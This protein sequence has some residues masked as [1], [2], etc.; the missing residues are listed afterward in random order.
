LT[1]TAATGVLSLTAL[2]VIPTT[3]EESNWNTAYG[4]GNHAGLYTPIAHKTTEDAI[5]GLV[6]CNGA[7]TYSA[8]TIGSD[9]QAYNAGLAD[10]AAL[11]KTDSNVIVGNG[12]NWV[13][14]SGATVRTSLGLGT[15]DDVSFKSLTLAGTGTQLNAS[16]EGAGFL[17]VTNVAS[18]VQPWH[19]TAYTCTK[20]RGTLA[21]PTAVQDGDYV[22]SYEATAY[23]G[24]QQRYVGGF[25]L[26]IEGAVSDN[27]TPSMFYIDTSPGFNGT[28]Y[29][30]IHSNGYVGIGYGTSAVSEMLQVNGKIRAATAFNLNG[31]DGVTQAAS[32]GKVCDVTALAG[33][34]ATAQTQIT[35]IADGAHSLAGITSI[36]TANGRITAMS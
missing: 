17:I 35:Y 11:A 10:I 12:T 2:Y 15:T 30:C 5:N 14:E 7:G 31:T 20:S 6:F 26:N 34:I 36:T 13:A 25:F 27:N 24:D 3:T 22:F 21:S 19:R 18:S 9:V 29:F 1:Y 33:G 32:A 28:T 16:A 8:K 4:W 23:D